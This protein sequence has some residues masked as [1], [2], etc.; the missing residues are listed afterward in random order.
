MLFFRGGSPT[1]SLAPMDDSG[2]IESITDDLIAQRVIIPAPILGGHF[3]NFSTMPDGYHW[4]LDFFNA[5]SGALKRFI[6]IKDNSTRRKYR[7]E[8]QYYDDVSQVD[9]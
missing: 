4:F 7:I 8:E 6:V 3:G 1:R 5:E 9:W 2:A